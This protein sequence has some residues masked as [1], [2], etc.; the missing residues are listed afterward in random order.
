MTNDL[1][2]F[3]EERKLEVEEFFNFLSTIN[4]KKTYKNEFLILKSQSILLLYN[5]IEGS[6]NKGIEYIIDSINDKMLKYSEIDEKIKIIWYKHKASNIRNKDDYSEILREIENYIN[7]EV[8]ID[9]KKF[10]KNNS[11]YFSAGNLDGNAIKK[12]L[13]K[14]FEIDF[15]KQE[16]RLKRIKDDRNFLAHGEKSFKEIGRDKS[17]EE[18]IE[19]K[20]KSFEFLDSYMEKIEEYIENEKYLV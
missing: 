7:Q 17:L 6:V 12:M 3:F 10:R 15:S 8:E 16:Y 11:S 20:K 1:R 4:D 5:L 2:E 14:R 19:T 18:L 13:E 9:I